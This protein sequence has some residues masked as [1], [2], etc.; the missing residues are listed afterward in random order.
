MVTN[1]FLK[2][3]VDPAHLQNYETHFKDD[4]RDK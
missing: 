3:D 2:H 4:S 1:K